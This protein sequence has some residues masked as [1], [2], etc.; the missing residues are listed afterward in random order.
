MNTCKMRQL[1]LPPELES[2]ILNRIAAKEQHAAQFR[3]ATF[4]SI[5]LGSLVG[6]VPA[7]MYLLQSF[8]QSGMYHYS[9]LLISDSDGIS[10]YWQ[11]FLLSIIESLPVLAVVIFL[12]A[13]GIFL[14]SL[15]RAGGDI[16]NLR[17]A[18][19]AF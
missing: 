6:S 11:E 9:S 5:A 12:S 4:G 10:Q 8:S 16:R 18:N 2:A 7:F 1:S 19:I 3:F 15:V 14:W 17:R 13:V